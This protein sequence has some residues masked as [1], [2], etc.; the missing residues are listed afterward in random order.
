MKIKIKRQVNVTNERIALVNF[1]NN[2]QPWL[3]TLNKTFKCNV[4]VNTRLSTLHLNAM[5][6]DGEHTLDAMFI[7][8]MSDDEL[9]VIS[10]Q[11]LSITKMLINSFG[12]HFVSVKVV[13]NIN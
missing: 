2:D 1:A 12:I 13:I 3:Q 6:C 5:Q 10:L 7:R 9:M 4:M 11:L 8:P